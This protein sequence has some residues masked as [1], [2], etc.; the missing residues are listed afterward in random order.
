MEKKGYLS[1]RGKKWCLQFKGIIAGLIAQKTPKPLSSKW[2]ELIDDYAKH[3]EKHSGAFL[4]ATIRIN[5]TIISP[6]DTIHGARK[7]LK[8]FEDWV[9][10]SAYVKQLME[11]GVI[12]FDLI[13]N[14]TLLT[15]VLSEASNEQIQALM[16]DWNIIK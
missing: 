14:Q 2:T 11:T 16:K 3:F 15:V 13:S 6:I 4:G 12:N 9:D 10:L 5:E 7:T 1:K 8:T